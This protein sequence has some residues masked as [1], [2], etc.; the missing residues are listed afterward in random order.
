MS[1]YYFGSCVEGDKPCG[2]V[3]I[4]A[5]APQHDRHLSRPSPYELAEVVEDARLQAL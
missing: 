1:T 5:K 2:S 4:R 3:G